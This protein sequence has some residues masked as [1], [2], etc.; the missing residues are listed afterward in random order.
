MRQIPQIYESNKT[1]I[2]GSALGSLPDAISCSVTEELNGE[3]SLEM[4]YQMGGRNA[5]LLQVGR[6]I[7]AMPNQYGTTQGFRIETIE[8]SLDGRMDISA[9]HVSMDLSNIVLFSFGGNISLALTLGYL[10]SKAHPTNSFTFDTTLDSTQTG[11]CMFVPL[12]SAREVMLSQDNSVAKVFGGEWKFDNWRATLTHRG[13]T[14][15]VQIAYG[16]NLTAF[17]ETDTLGGYDAI[18]PF[19][20]YQGETNFNWWEITNTSVCATA[21]LVYVNNTGST[22]GFPRVRLVDLSEYF[23]DFSTNPPTDSTLY[24]AARNY[25]QLH[26]G[27]STASYSTEF[28]DLAKLLGNTERVELGDTL[29]IVVP[30]FGITDMVTRVVSITYDCLLDRNTSVVVGDKKVTLADTLAK[31]MR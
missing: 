17:K 16:K 13:T 10:S 18:Y 20:Q 6:I 5:D 27:H 24:A 3:F 28:V 19:A 15:N 22:Y 8:K 30:M 9:N 12:K 4:T 31:L 11:N 14:R 21:P 29:H 7:S 26:S 25:I 23:T 1:A 2:D